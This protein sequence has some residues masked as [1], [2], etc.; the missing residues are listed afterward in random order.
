MRS[1]E[2][3]GTFQLGDLP[4][5]RL[6][7]GAMHLSGA[8]IFGPPEDRDAAL[9]V[10]RDA[11]KSNRASSDAAALLPDL[12]QRL[13]DK[14]EVATDRSGAAP[15]FHLGFVLAVAGFAAVS[16]SEAATIT[17]TVTDSTGGVV[18]A[19]TVT[20]VN[21]STGISTSAL[22]PG[23]AGNTYVFTLSA[24][25]GVPLYSWSISGLPPGLSVSAQTGVIA[26]LTKWN[27]CVRSVEEIAPTIDQAFMEMHAGRPRP[28]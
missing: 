22:P 2:R 6:G 13:P 21:S 14:L 27:R 15:R 11:L 23:V 19:V 10:L 12:D 1:L 26:G 16:S 7:Y 9:A 5:R 24:I 20:V 28:P 3:S 18:P 25:G 4:V 8:G 17:G